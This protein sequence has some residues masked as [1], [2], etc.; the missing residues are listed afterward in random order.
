MIPSDSAE[1]ER[2]WQQTADAV[3][4]EMAN[5]EEELARDFAEMH[6]RLDAMLAEQRAIVNRLDAT[7][8][9]DE[10]N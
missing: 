5:F 3:R 6:D 1:L 7:I 10:E 4:E 2:L 9:R 8:A